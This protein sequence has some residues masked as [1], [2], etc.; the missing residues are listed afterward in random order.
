MK[1]TR[2]VNTARS[3]P[4]KAPKVNRKPSTAET[5][6][7][8]GDGTQDLPQLP[9]IPSGQN[10]A[11]K[12][13]IDNLTTGMKKVKINLLTKAQRDAKQATKPAS[14]V[15]PP[16][17]APTKIVPAQSA[18]DSTINLNPTSG[19]PTNDATPDTKNIAII[20]P[21]PVAQPEL[22]RLEPQP[23]TPKPETSRPSVSSRIQQ[24]QEAASV[25]LPASSPPLPPPTKA[26]QVYAAVRAQAPASTPTDMFVPYQPEGPTPAPAPRNEPLK[27]L[28]PNTSTP[29]PSPMKRGGL[30]DL[31]V[32][33]ATSTIPFGVK[34][35]S[36]STLKNDELEV[37]KSEESEKEASIWEVPETPKRP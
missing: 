26:P 5:I 10:D 24:L 19:I 13:D 17:K 14:V 34:S 15:P 8:G 11:L 3:D 23:S 30:A 35:A 25:P 20:Q 33:T 31:P 7:L 27:W 29:T 1:K 2:T 12:S 32:F 37:V 16:T 36:P 4:N 9:R 28:E 22:P 21:N 6:P 18:K